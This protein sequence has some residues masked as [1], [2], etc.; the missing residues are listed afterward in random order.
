MKNATACNNFDVTLPSHQQHLLAFLETA[1]LITEDTYVLNNYRYGSRTYVITVRN[2]RT[3]ISY[4]L[5]CH[6]N[7]TNRLLTLINSSPLN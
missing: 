3:F 5:M 1:I 7:F 2:A 4:S 6:C